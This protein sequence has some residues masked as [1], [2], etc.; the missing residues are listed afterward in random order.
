MSRISARRIVKSLNT[1]YSGAVMGVYHNDE[2]IE[3]EYITIRFDRHFRQDPSILD[4]IY[5]YNDLRIR[6]KLVITSYSIHYTKLYECVVAVYF[7]LISGILQCQKCI[8]V[9]DPF[10]KSCF[11]RFL[12]IIV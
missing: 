4:R 12:F 11:K 3:Q 9:I 7:E 1:A 6:I 2:N 10:F 8:I 5:L